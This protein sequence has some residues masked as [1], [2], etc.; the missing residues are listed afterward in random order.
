M[1]AGAQ[2]QMAAG[3]PDG[4]V[5]GDVDTAELVDELLEALEVDLET[6]SRVEVCRGSVTACGD[7]GSVRGVDVVDRAVAV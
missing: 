6:R 7:D 2:G 1:L 4:P 5:G 3:V